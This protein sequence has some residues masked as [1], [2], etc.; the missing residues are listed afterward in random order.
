MFDLLGFWSAVTLTVL[1]IPVML[2]L[3]V[4]SDFNDRVREATGYRR[5]FGLHTTFQNWGLY[6]EASVF[7]GIMSSVVSGVV[8]CVIGMITLLKG[9]SFIFL[10]SKFCTLISPVAALFL[11]IGALLVLYVALAKITCFIYTAQTKLEDL[12][13]KAK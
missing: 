11:S 13:N 5:N 6:S 7:V 1:P 3:L 8:L 9:E 2:L 10:L 12:E 4:V